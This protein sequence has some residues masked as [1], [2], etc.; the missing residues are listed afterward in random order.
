MAVYLIHLDKPYHHARHYIGFAES[1][2]EARLKDHRNGNGA[3]FMQVV[4]DA[5]IPWRLARVWPDGDRHF[6]RRL[7]N[8]KNSPRLCPICRQGGSER[9]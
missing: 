9:S 5:G 8:R 6:E 1:N 7:K 4:T 2:V 3:R